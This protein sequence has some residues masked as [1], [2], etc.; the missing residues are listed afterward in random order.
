LKTGQS[1]EPVASALVLQRAQT[2]PSTT[3][4]FSSFSPRSVAARSW[5]Q[6][7]GSQKSLSLM[8]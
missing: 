2:L 3:E 5:F 4:T 1:A 7:Q 8:V 6:L